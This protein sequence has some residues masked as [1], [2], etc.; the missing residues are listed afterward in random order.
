MPTEISSFLSPLKSQYRLSNC[1]LIK[2]FRKLNGR[3]INNMGDLKGFPD[4]FELYGNRLQTFGSWPSAAPIARESLARAGFYYTGSEL[5]VCC[6]SCGVKCG[7]WNFGDTAI[8]KHQELQPN[9]PFVKTHTDVLTDDSS[10]LVDPPMVPPISLAAAPSSN[11]FYSQVD[12]G[13]GS[14]ANAHKLL[15]SAPEFHRVWSNYESMNKESERA[16]TFKGWPV[17]FIRLEDMARAGFVYL[18]QGDRVQCVYCYGIV[19]EWE[20]DDNPFQDHLKHFPRCP[21]IRGERCGNISIED[22]L[23]GVAAGPLAPPDRGF[24]ECGHSSMP[25]LNL[26]SFELERQPSPEAQFM[27]GINAEESLQQLNVVAHQKPKFPMYATRDSRKES[28]KNWSSDLPQD[29]ESMVEAGFF[30]IGTTDS[31]K[32]FQCGGGLKNWETN[33]IPWEEHAR[34]FPHCRYV[35][36]HKGTEYV[37]KSKIKKPPLLTNNSEEEINKEPAAASTSNSFPISESELEQLMNQDVV[38]Q[39]LQLGFER[40]KVYK[41][42]E[43]RMRTAGYQ[44]SDPESLANAV[45]ELGDD[46]QPTEQNET[47]TTSVC[48]VSNEEKQ[49]PTTSNETEEEEK[50]K[51]LSAPNGPKASGS[52]DEDLRLCRVCMDR[53]MNVVFLPCSHFIAC[54]DCASIMD[55]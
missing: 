55:N 48:E 9:C 21:F 4:H 25:S 15:S 6:F 36:L 41:T 54:V 47:N 24:D 50:P 7:H 53:E 38:K 12:H 51:C 5:T 37:T 14:P 39:V 22:E 3:H 28:F 40:D 33:D 45:L 46:V 26:N 23:R 8:R 16:K 42:L 27:K 13:R 32:C 10:M 19:A 35:I 34:W 43:I 49:E 17:T 1:Q 20:V 2:L 31:V 30:Y 29:V 11:M 44:F 18:K 52:Q